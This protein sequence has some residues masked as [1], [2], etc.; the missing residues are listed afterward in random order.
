MNNTELETLQAALRQRWPTRT[1]AKVQ[2]YVGKFFECKRVGTR[3]SARVKGNH[4]I[5]T[6]S[7]RV[8]GDTTV[9]ACS[10]YI[11]KHGYCHHC[12]ALAATFLNDPAAFPA[13][14][15]KE[16]QDVRGL[17]DLNAF[18]AHTTLEA[19]LQQLKEQG[20]TQIAFAE[21]IGT[22]SQHLA[23]VKKSEL[24]NRFHNELGALKLA[25]LWVL[26][27]RDELAAEQRRTQR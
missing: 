10:C 14:E 21:G 13:V 17:S 18:L 9:S 19:L 25:C 22:S 27:H 26:E 1:D 2:Q 6:V 11:G 12:A 4:G 20:I 3:I 8:E 16:R 5:Y 15:R 7:I 24:R 23:A